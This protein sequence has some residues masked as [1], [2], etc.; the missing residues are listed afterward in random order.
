MKRQEKAVDGNGVRRGLV[1]MMILPVSIGIDDLSS[2]LF[3]SPISS[4]PYS[5][6]RLPSRPVLPDLSLVLSLSPVPDESCVHVDCAGGCDFECILDYGPLS[7]EYV[8][9]V[10]FCINVCLSLKS[11]FGRGKP[12]I[13]ASLN[14]RNFVRNVFGLSLLDTNSDI[15]VVELGYF[16]DQIN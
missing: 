9:C 13:S 4:P 3:T 12:D 2:T 10:D 8:E 16:E 14:C 15:P 6:P 5:L 11:L 7:S 1:G